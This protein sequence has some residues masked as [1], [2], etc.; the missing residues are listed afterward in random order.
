MTIRT[1]LAVCLLA[2]PAFAQPGDQPPPPVDPTIVPP[3]EPPPQPPPP[4]PPHRAPPVEVRPAMA[5]A[6]TQ[7]QPPAVRP[8]GFS[9]GIGVGYRFP[10]SLQTPNITSVRFRLGSGIELEP[11]VVFANTS[12]SVDTGSAQGSDASEAGVAA[13][14]RFPVVSHRRTELQLLGGLG[15]DYLGEDPDDQTPDD[16][17]STTT[18]AAR[19][20]VAVAVWIT[21]HMQV[22]MSATNSLISYSKKRQEMGQQSV[23]VTNDTTYGLIFDP[24]VAFMIHLY[25]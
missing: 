1:F 19:Y 13:L 24:N 12:H 3:T 10:T 5:L 4:Q 7:P 25:N 16:V 11:T 6:P 20:G 8:A 22:S 21:P 17:T 14:L 9:L 18:V 23:Q 2:G 15:F